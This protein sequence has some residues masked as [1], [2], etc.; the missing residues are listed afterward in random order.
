ME[1]G[2]TMEYSRE[3][4]VRKLLESIG[5][6]QIKIVTGIRRCG[7]SYLL[8]TLFK[9]QLLE[10]GVR[11]DHV[12]EIDLDGFRNRPLRDPNAFLD[13]VDSRVR[14]GEKHFLLVD[15]VQMLDSFSDVLN[16]LTRSCSLDVYVTGSNARLLSRD[17]ATEFRGRGEEI[18]M[19]PLS[20][21]EFMEQ[22][23][24]DV[25]NGYAEYVTYGG[26]PPVT[27]REG[28]ERKAAYLKS[29]LDET[30]IRDLVER[31]GIRNE[32]DLGDL[33]DVLSSNIGTLTNPTKIA[34]TFKSEKHST[35][36]P[37][38][39]E[40]YIRHLEESFLFEKAV[41]YDVKGRRYIGANAKYYAI[42]LGLRNARLSFRQL[43]ETH[44]LE[45]V[46]Y[47]ELRGRGYTVDVGV[48]TSYRRNGAGKT[49]R[50]NYEVDFVCNQG[51][52]RYYIQSA[53]ALP[54]P[55]KV[56]QEEASLVR[57][58]DSFKKVIVTKDGLAPHYNEE[59][60]LMMNVFDFLLNPASLQF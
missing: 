32:G 15:E 33:V 55:E 6:G 36:S 56:K 39:V 23:E 24:G 16:D 37:R 49:E 58:D 44:M 57:I 7:K 46:V 2:N 9:R 17:V 8:G 35:L 20:F 1:L 48:V 28:D 38:T 40:Q 50:V 4:Y 34:N 18:P 45:N 59:G 19:R 60:I 13:Y 54:T 10:G 27:L 31:Y 12:I 11:P 52:Q 47:N 42:D 29:V 26:L 43:E 53:F 30:Y 21:S 3:T 41:R 14:D 51:S 5:S 22:Y 25:R